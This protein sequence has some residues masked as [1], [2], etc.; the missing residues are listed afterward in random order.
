MGKY[1][2]TSALVMQDV[3]LDKYDG[4]IN[5]D[6]HS[7]RLTQAANELSPDDM[8]ESEM[9]ADVHFPYRDQIR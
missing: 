9:I 6:V 8:I 2:I 3:L 1:S 7:L 4:R 5:L